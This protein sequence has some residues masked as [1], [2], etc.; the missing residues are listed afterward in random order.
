MVEFTGCIPKQ[1]RKKDVENLKNSQHDTIKRIDN[2]RDNNSQ[3][4]VRNQIPS[5]ER[6]LNPRSTTFTFITPKK[7]L[8]V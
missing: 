6:K 1:K 5:S 2:T 4:K 8:Q 7:R 3:P